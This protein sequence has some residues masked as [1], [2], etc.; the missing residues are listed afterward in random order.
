MAGHGPRGCD[1]CNT[2]PSNSIRNCYCVLA[3]VCLLAN[4]TRCGCGPGTLNS[5]GQFD[6]TPDR[7]A[8]LSRPSAAYDLPA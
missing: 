4:G 5:W 8:D 3:R 2:A 6:A 1:F 7:P